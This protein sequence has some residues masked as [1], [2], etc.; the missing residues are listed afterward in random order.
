MRWKFKNIKISGPFLCE[1]KTSKNK[2]YCE[3]K[4]KT[5]IRTLFARETSQRKQTSVPD[6][7]C[8]RK[9]A[10]TTT[11]ISGPFLGEKQRANT[12]SYPALFVREKRQNVIIR[13]SLAG[14]KIFV[15]FYGNSTLG[16][17]AVSHL[18]T[19]LSLAVVFR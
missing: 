13:T 16:S 7:F 17:E 8:A 1:K 6:P 18:G 15:F 14:E 12:H 19:G 10:K 4:G 2:Q 9:N 11:E 5:I 3:R